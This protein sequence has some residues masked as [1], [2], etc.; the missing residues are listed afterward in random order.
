MASHIRTPPLERGRTDPGGEVRHGAG[1]GGAPPDPRPAVVAFAPLLRCQRHHLWEVDT[2]HVRDLPRDHARAVCRD[3][4]AQLRT[5]QRVTMLGQQPAIDSRPRRGQWLQDTLSMV[6]SASA[7]RASIWPSVTTPKTVAAW[8][9]RFMRWVL[10]HTG[11]A[12]QVVTV[13]IPK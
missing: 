5:W 1:G 11:G 6:R 3:D 4:V 9:W 12:V 10:C 13:R 7:N 8:G 2:A